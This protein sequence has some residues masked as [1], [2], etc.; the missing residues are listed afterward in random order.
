MA[1]WTWPNGLRTIPYVTDEFGPRKS[2]GGIGSTNHQGID[3]I[4]FALNRSA[5]D[6]VV[7]FAGWNG[8]GGNEVR[9]VHPGGTETRYKHNASILVS[10]GQQVAR[11]QPLGVM[12]TTGDSTGV[13]LHFETRL[14]AG[15]AAM[16]PRDFMGARL[17]ESAGIDYSNNGEEEMNKAQEDLLKAVAENSAESRRMLGVLLGAIAPAPSE[18]LP[19]SAKAIAEALAPMIPALSFPELVISP[20]K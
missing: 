14:S 16:N 18:K 7:T 13:H 10:V 4:G 19:V 9:V 6:G 8:G 11:A 12:G 5:A 2:P 20:R 3:L 1:G 17:A 15:S